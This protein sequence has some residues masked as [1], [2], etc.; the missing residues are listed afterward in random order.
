MHIMLS[1]DQLWHS[2]DETDWRKILDLYPSL[3][4]WSEIRD[5]DNELA[6]L[7]LEDIRSQNAS[8]WYAWLGEKYFPWKYYPQN[9]RQWRHL[10]KFVKEGN[11]LDELYEIKERLLSFDVAH[12]CEGLVIACTIKGLAVAGAS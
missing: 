10:E 12:I 11:G 6:S 8:E 7:G 3:I 2:H 1:M 9:R 5:I 4:K